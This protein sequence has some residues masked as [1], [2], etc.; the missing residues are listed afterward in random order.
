MEAHYCYDEAAQT[1]DTYPLEV[2]NGGPT[3]ESILQAGFYR[4]S[5]GT[6]DGVNC[7]LC[8]TYLYQWEEGD[9]PLDCHLKASF[10][11]NKEYCPLAKAIS[12]RQF[13]PQKNSALFRVS[14]SSDST[15]P[16]LKKTKP[17][18]TKN[19]TGKNNTAS[20]V[21]SGQCTTDKVHPQEV[22]TGTRIIIEVIEPFTATTLYLSGRCLQ[23]KI[24]CKK[25]N[26]YHIEFDDYVQKSPTKVKKR[27]ME[28][29][30]YLSPSHYWPSWAL[31][32]PDT[33]LQKYKL[34]NEDYL[35]TLQGSLTSLSN[36]A[37]LKSAIILAAKRLTQAHIPLDQAYWS[38]PQIYVAM[39]YDTSDWWADLP[40]DAAMRKDQNDVLKSNIALKTN[41]EALSKLD[42]QKLLEQGLLVSSLIHQ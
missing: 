6:N 13:S 37:N 34:E 39:L 38:A 32:Q 24:L 41:I 29:K 22:E 18:T 7:T 40:E 12:T 25:T 42:A 23:E 10:K 5:D 1:F 21:C 28:E 31:H 4:K 3:K 36:G 8:K 16:V 11:R 2:V 17:H 27:K 30:T 19:S 14:G 26:Y 9:D 15:E 33:F 35:N 20:I